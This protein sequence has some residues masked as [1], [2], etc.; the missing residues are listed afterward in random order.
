MNFVLC[1]LL[2]YCIAAM[3]LWMLVFFHYYRA[4]ELD[5]DE[6]DPQLVYY[7]TCPWNDK[8]LLVPEFVRSAGCNGSDWC[9]SITCPK[10]FIGEAEAVRAAIALG[11]KSDYEVLTDAQVLDITLECSS[12]YER[13]KY[14][15]R[16]RRATDALFP[17]AF[18][19]LLHSG[20]AQFERLLRAIYRPQNVYCLHVDIKSSKAF[21]EAVFAVARCFDNVFLAAKRQ[22]IVHAGFSRLQVSSGCL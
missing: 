3:M 13:G 21:Y 5:N 18:N 14:E 22:H 19:V 2:S 10:L 20:A 7:D 1:A 15:R 4:L 11:V 17:V 6:V 9:K 12:F 8:L 16:P